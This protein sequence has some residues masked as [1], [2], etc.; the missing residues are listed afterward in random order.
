MVKVV[1]YSS[2]RLRSAWQPVA[3][4][5]F[6]SALVLAIGFLGAT[7]CAG[8]DNGDPRFAER[9][10][11]ECRQVVESLS[12]RFETT[13]PRPVGSDPSFEAY[14]EYS[15]RMQAQYGEATDSIAAGLADLEGLDAPGDRQ[16]AFDDLVAVLHEMADANDLADAE[17]AFQETGSMDG[18]EAAANAVDGR[19]DRLA[20]LVDRLRI[21]CA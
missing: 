5:R 13:L 3:R 21:T 4:W 16:A 18:Y 14:E 12:D 15:D 2:P 1:Y 11:A 19:R 8:P 10:S 17:T 20:E 9:A 6:W 7:A